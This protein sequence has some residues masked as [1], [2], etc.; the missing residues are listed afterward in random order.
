[1][2]IIEEIS[3]SQAAEIL[4]SKALGNRQADRNDDEDDDGIPDS[5]PGSN[6]SPLD[7]VLRRISDLEQVLPQTEDEDESRTDRPNEIRAEA[8]A[9]AEPSAE[10]Q[11]ESKA[12]KPGAGEA[13]LLGALAT[14]VNGPTWFVIKAVLV[15]LAA[16]L[17]LLLHVAIQ[18]SSWMVLLNVVFLIVIAGG[19]AL[20]LSWYVSQIGLVSVEKQM[21]EL[22]LV[23][24]PSET[25]TKKTE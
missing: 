19:L 17:V 20:L 8:E 6:Q 11:Q 25:G 21:V 16:S 9:E 14:G 15:A 13:V 3:D 22:K 23:D 12:K 7:E 1:M 24:E 10:D 2:A 18:S 4:G 5:N